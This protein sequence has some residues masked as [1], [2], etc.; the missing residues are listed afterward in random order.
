M[1]GTRGSYTIVQH[2]SSYVRVTA[3]SVAC[4]HS[5][6]TVPT[7]PAD[8]SEGGIRAAKNYVTEKIEPKTST[9]IPW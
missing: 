2:F 5:G 1:E 8:A 9:L 3:V 4:S 6:A 7:G